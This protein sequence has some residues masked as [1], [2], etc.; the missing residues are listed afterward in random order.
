MSNFILKKNQPRSFPK[1]LNHFAFPAAIYE[2]SSCSA[3]LSALSIV[4]LFNFCHSSRCVVV[5]YCEFNLLFLN[6]CLCWV[7]IDVLICHL[8][9]FFAGKRQK[10]FKMSFANIFSCLWFVFFLFLTVSLENRSLGFGFFFL[11]EVQCISFFCDLWVLC[12]T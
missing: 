3:S 9:L 8:Y 2:I 12:L 1:W 7:S 10:L 11:N 4:S 6:G 5:L